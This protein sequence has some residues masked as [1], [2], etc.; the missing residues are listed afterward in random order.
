METYFLDTETTGLG[1][2][3]Q[4]VELSIV[5]ESGFIAFDSLIN[6]SR[7]I[8]SNASRVHGITDE[9]VSAAPVF[10]DVWP[11]IRDILCDNQVV[12]YN[13][14]FDKKFFPDK[15]ACASEVRCAM[16]EFAEFYRRTASSN[17]KK[18]RLLEAA[19]ISGHQWVG[20][21][22]RAL[23]DS[24]ACRAVW[25][26]LNGKPVSSPTS[27]PPRRS[28]EAKL[29]SSLPDQT[30]ANWRKVF[31]R[32]TA[33]RISSPPDSMEAVAPEQTADIPAKQEQSASSSRRE[34]RMFYWIIDA[35]ILLF[36]VFLLYF[37]FKQ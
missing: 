19:E 3:D 15:L 35:I 37:I 7:P 14:S 33:P 11:S 13:A 1:A 28:R 17:R 30:S 16:L 10:S 29:T 5:H 12:I 36:F 18:L 34:Q 20:G 4:I 31:P 32:G 2:S 9:M 22:H 27:L 8:P 24:F 25:F 23:A 6:P 21:Q 26:H